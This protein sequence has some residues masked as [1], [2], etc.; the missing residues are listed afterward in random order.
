MSMHGGGGGGGGGRM[1]LRSMRQNRDILEHQIKKGTLPRMLT[2]ARQYR[3]LLVIF[4]IAVVLDAVVSS[5]DAAHLPGD[6]RQRA[7]GEEQGTGDRAGAAGRRT[8]ALRRRPLALRASDVG[9]DRRGVD[10]RPAREGLHAHPG[11]ADRVLL[12]HPDRRPDQSLEQRRDRRPAGLH[13]PVLERRRQR[14]PGDDRDRHHA[15]PELADHAGG[16][17]VAAGLLDPGASRRAQARHAVPTGHGTQRRDEHG[18]DRTLQRLGR[19]AG[20][21]VRT[22][23]RTSASSSRAAPARSATSASNRRCTSASSSSRSR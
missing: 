15:R 8:R 3:A 13:R 11:D 20:Q 10:L 2:Y 19:H 1:G 4:L 7:A 14:D 9:G 21:A 22:S 18:D 16:A 17:A 12:A 6:H 5:V 23:A